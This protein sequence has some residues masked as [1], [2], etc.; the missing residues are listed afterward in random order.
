MALT[1]KEQWETFLKAAGVPDAESTTY[2]DK[3]VEQRTSIR[4]LPEFERD[5]FRDLG[6][7]VLG[8]IKNI[9]R[10]A[11]ST[12]S[13]P[14]NTGAVPVNQQAPLMKPP[15]AQLPRIDAEMT[16]PQFRKFKI[17]WT[18]FKQSVRLQA[19]QIHSYLYNC[20]DPQ[21]IVGS[22]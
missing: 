17:D 2:A 15:A 11:K 21:C 10:H 8:D 7:T 16:K 14:S 5:D 6:I 13:T 19:D 3:L 1:S 12:N 20:C 4:N 9:I 22:I 18:M